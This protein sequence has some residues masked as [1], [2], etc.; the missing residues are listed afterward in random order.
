MGV[1]N[2]SVLWLFVLLSLIS[3]LMMLSWR[4]YKKLDK[5]SFSNFYFNSLIPSNSK[6]IMSYLAALVSF[7]LIITGISNPYIYIKEPTNFYS[8]IKLYFMLDVSRSMSYTED[9]KP[10]RLEAAKKEIKHFYEEIEGNYKSS[11]IPFAG[12]PNPYYCPLSYSKNIFLTMLDDVNSETVN[13]PGTNII[14]AFS[15]VNLLTKDTDKNDINIIVFLS[16]GGKE[17]GKTLNAAEL[18]S[19]INDLKS[20]NFKIY[21][22]GIGSSA[23]TP[24]VKR[25]WGGN[26]IDYWRD[27][28]G[29]IYYSELDERTLMQISK[30]G[31]GSYSR[32][33]DGTELKN[34]LVKVVEENKSLEKIEHE[35]KRKPIG[36]WFFGI[37]SI[38]LIS[39]VFM[40]SKLK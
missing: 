32:F 2:P 26:F 37:S 36:H 3:F 22:I 30:W 39:L 6:R 17:E 40:G 21:T 27:D 5:K 4:Q 10:N 28:K 13:V 11:L 15:S 35:Y 9:I 7:S 19:H 8:N 24:L 38:I 25:D 14:E 31:G 34:T 23:P 33:K 12:K 16:D 29:N 18:I 20:R 1:E